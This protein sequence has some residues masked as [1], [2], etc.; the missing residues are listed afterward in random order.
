MVYFNQTKMFGGDRDEQVWM[1]SVRAVSCGCP[2]YSEVPAENLQVSAHRPDENP[3][4]LCALF[5]PAPKVPWLP[6]GGKLAAGEERA[7]D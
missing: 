2:K 1:L 6:F 5:A 3:Y 4:A 7:A